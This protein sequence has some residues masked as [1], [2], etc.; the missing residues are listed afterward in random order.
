M[1]DAEYIHW[2]STFIF[3]LFEYFY[4]KFSRK[5]FFSRATRDLAEMSRCIAIRDSGLGLFCLASNKRKPPLSE[6]IFHVVQA[7]PARWIRDLLARRTARMVDDCTYNCIP[8][9]NCRATFLHRS[10]C[11]RRSIPANRL[12]PPQC[13][14]HWPP[15]DRILGI[16]QKHTARAPSGERF[17]F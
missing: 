8:A 14:S 17:R 4:I 3:F 5:W 10:S 15:P 6:L 1:H 16:E 12:L 2:Y 13:H 11:A 7:V 9:A